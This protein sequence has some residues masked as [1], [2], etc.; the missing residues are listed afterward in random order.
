MNEEEVVEAEEV[1]VEIQEVHPWDFP[2]H[3]VSPLI[4][5]PY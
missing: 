1:V 4:L 5:Q 2:T 3:P